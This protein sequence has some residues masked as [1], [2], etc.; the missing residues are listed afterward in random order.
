MTTICNT[1]GGTG[2]VKGLHNWKGGGTREQKC[3]N[4]SPAPQIEA[5]SA[6]QAGV[7]AGAVGAVGWIDDGGML[8]WKG[9]PLPDGS[10]IYAVPQPSPPPAP[11]QPG[12]EVERGY[13][14]PSKEWLNE[15]LAICDDSDAQAGV[16]ASKP[17]PCDDPPG[18]N[19]HNCLGCDDF[20]AARAAP[21]PATDYDHGPQA[22]TI[23]EAARDVGQW[24][25]ERPN[26]PI[27]LRHV[28]MLA[29][30]AQ[31]PQ[32]ADE[33]ISRKQWI[34]QAVRVYLIAGDTEDQALE[35]AKALCREQNWDPLQDDLADPYDAAMSDVEG[36]GPAPQPATA[37]AVDAQK[38]GA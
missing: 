21:Q 35:C 25:N 3:W 26:R 22:T 29:H 27:D 10:D 8:F 32:P 7:P 1:C 13:K 16:P 30:Y 24:L 28:A 19:S 12:Q 15:R 4:C 38:G 9:E 37:D 11:A 23:E 20:K 31:A 14:A 17:R 34:E 18:C 2:V 5:L 33:G 36:R 6:A